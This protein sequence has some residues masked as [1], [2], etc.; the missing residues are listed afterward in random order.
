MEFVEDSK[1]VILNSGK[2][3]RA[4]QNQPTTVSSAVY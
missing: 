3:D 1:K 2:S 4:W